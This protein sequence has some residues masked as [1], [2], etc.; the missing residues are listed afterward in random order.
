MIE[1]E[2]KYRLNEPARDRLVSALRAAGAIDE[3]EQF[4][5]N[6]LFFGGSLDPARSVL[7]LRR[8]AGRATLT[9]KERFP[10]DSAIKHQ[11]EDET[12]VAGPDAL[13]EILDALGFKPSLVYEKKRYTWRLPDTEIVVDQLP[14]GWYAEIEGTEET[15]IAAEK[16]L[17]LADTGSEELTYPQLAQKF[18]RDRNGVIESR[19]PS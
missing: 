7:R 11:R 10:S 5:E 6:I 18:G 9:Y 3:G 16:V 14:F 13:L 17:G 2:K 8:V 15:I 4:E 1:I 12:E 19:F